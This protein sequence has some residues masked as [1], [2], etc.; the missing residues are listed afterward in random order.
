MA[1]AAPRKLRVGVIGA[2]G[3][4]QGAHIPGYKRLLDQVELVAIADVV[5]E[6]ARQVA[7]E[8][9][10]RAH[11]ASY[12][13]MLAKE[14]LDAVSVCTPNKFHAPA[15][16]AAL[17]AGCHVICEKPPATTG[18]EARAMAEAAARA[19]KVLTFG[20]HYRFTPEVE[21]AR[22]WAEQGAFG[23]I[24]FGR[25]TAQR[26]YGIP[27]WGVFTNKALQG[28]GPLI[29]I[30]VHMLDSCLW[31]MGYPEPS[32]VWGVTYTKLGDKP[33]AV[34]GRSWNYK[35][36]T[37]EDV[38]NA[39]IRFADGATLVL[40]SS[41]IANIEPMEEMNVRLS[42]TRAGL[43]LFPLGI[44]AEEHGTLVN[45]AAVWLPQPPG[46][47]H[48]AEIAHFVRCCRGEA[49]PRSTPEEAVKISRIIEAIYRSADSGR[50]EK[51]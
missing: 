16:I 47:A 30:G 36:Y 33:P 1:S 44:F 22:R 31:I 23:E 35:D 13:E 32:E 10:F 4:A 38:C 45:K 37:V 3:I 28:G 42:G 39:F 26:R 11:Y 17:Q 9:G 18:E 15:T 27:G 48:A 14:E 25:V 50:P 51:V 34:V 20:F 40:E 29:D 8:H 5:E 46:G 43:R 12:E 41:F 19:G 2:G 6:R 49:Q 24:Y 21:A 7:A